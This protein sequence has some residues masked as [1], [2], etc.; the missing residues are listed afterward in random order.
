M[1]LIVESPIFVA[2][3][4][5]CGSS[6]V[7]QML[8]AAEIPCCG[9]FPAF[10]PREVGEGRDLSKLLAIPAAMKML[11]PHHDEWPES[12]GARIIWLDRDVREQAK[13]QI[14]FIRHV[15]ELAVPSQAWRKIA[16]AL[17][18]D[19]IKCRE[20]WERA[21]TEPMILRFEDILDEPLLAAR[22]IAEFLAIPDT[23]VPLMAECVLRRDAKC[24][25]DMQIEMALM[26]ALSVSER[27]GVSTM[28]A[29]RR[30]MEAR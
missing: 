17:R 7:M 25:P 5:R 30:L 27:Y 20:W 10:E 23:R 13:S 1:E 22:R 18:S 9:E 29:A 11:D 4:G 2:G 16:Q 8:H 6:L 3:L 24:R 26:S 14:K 15:A 19:R 21:A 28:M 12:F